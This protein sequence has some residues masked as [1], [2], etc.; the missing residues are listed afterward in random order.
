MKK[1]I[2]FGFPHCGTSILKSV[3]AHIPGVYEIVDEFQRVPDNI[4]IPDGTKY[5]LCK[6]PYDIPIQNYEDYIKIFIMRNPLFVFSSLNKRT[7]NAIPKDWF[8]DIEDYAQIIEKFTY[9]QKNPKKDLYLL[10]YEDMFDDNYLKL[11]EI[12]TE[13][14][15]QFDDKIFDNTNYKNLISTGIEKVPLNMP[16]RVGSCHT[17]FRTWQIN[18][19]FVNMN[20]NASIQLSN[21][22]ITRI[23]SNENI[24]E[25]YPEICSQVTHLLLPFLQKRS[26]SPD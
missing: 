4:S 6:Y 5:I 23:L 14:G 3:I 15:M 21:D 11:K 16:S 8:H 9:Y 10:R 18:Q 19:P 1:I 26:A 17:A 2:I 7:N 13:I 20:T 25:V 12:F 22:Q 24:T